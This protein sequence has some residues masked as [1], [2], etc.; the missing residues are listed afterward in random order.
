MDLVLSLA[1]SL[2][3]FWVFYGRAIPS[4]WRFTALWGL[5]RWERQFRWE[6]WGRDERSRKV[7]NEYITEMKFK[8]PRKKP[9]GSLKFLSWI[10]GSEVLETLECQVNRSQ[11]Q[12]ISELVWHTSCLWCQ[13]S[14][15]KRSKFHESVYCGSKHFPSLVLLSGQ[16]FEE[17]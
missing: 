2:H 15:R 12:P 4:Y 6:L 11:S 5:R 16:R 3:S 13:F 7:E 14:L 1:E 17:S 8:N 10:E 9:V